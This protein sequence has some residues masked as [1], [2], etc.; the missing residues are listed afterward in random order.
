MAAIGQVGAQQGK[1]GGWIGALARRVGNRRTRPQQE[2]SPRHIARIE[3]H[4]VFV[5]PHGRICGV[6]H[7]V[8][9][10]GDGEAECDS[11]RGAI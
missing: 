4:P 10:S 9:E 8:I 7:L 5:D 11:T 2:E 1:V 3:R 6:A